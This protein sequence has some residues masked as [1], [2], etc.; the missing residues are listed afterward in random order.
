V[1]VFIF[2]EKSADVILQ[3]LKVKQQADAAEKDVFVEPNT[4][5]VFPLNLSI[6]GS[7]AALPSSGMLLSENRQ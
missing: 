3:R 2:Q 6:P 5:L 4:S 1:Y 7:S